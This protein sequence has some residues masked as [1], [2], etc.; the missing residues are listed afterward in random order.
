[1]GGTYP[2][3]KRLSREAD[4]SPLR[5]ADVGNEWSCPFT[6]TQWGLT[7][8]D[9]YS[10]IPSGHATAQMLASH[11]GGPVRSQT[12]QRGIFGGQSAIS[13]SSSAFRRLRYS[14]SAAYL[15][16]QAGVSH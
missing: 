3:V 10:L 12:S 5:S 11:R 13:P 7:K 8:Q 14:T 15:M 2:A 16:P 1:M 4:R 9:I 6:P